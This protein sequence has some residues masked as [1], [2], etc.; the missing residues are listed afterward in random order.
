MWIP[1]CT[2]CGNYSKEHVC[3]LWYHF[4]FPASILAWFQYLWILLV[5]KRTICILINYLQDVKRKS[6]SQR[7]F[8]QCPQKTHFRIFVTVA[9]FSSFNCLHVVT[10][11]LPWTCR[12]LFLGNTSFFWNSRLSV[13]FAIV[14]FWGLL[15]FQNQTNCVL[16]NPM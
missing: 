8:Y 2:I 13:C 15:N 6:Q 3:W 4:I 16:C 5:K 11:N 9:S 1:A 7:L 14:Y 12:I 10:S